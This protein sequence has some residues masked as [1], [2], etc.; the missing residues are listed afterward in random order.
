[1]AVSATTPSRFDQPP[2]EATGSVTVL[3][4]PE[5]AAQH[6]VAAPEALRTLPG[7]DVREA[8]TLGEAA[9]LRIR[10]AEPF[11]T[12]VLLDGVRVNSPLRGDADLGNF[13]LDG[14]TQIE[15]VR[16]GYSA[17]YG[18]DAIGGAVNLRTLP[19]Q[20]PTEVTFFAEGGTFHT[21]REGVGVG[22]KQEWGFYR[23]AV[24]RTDTDG[25]FDH[26]RFGAAT[27]SGQLS[28]DLTPRSSITLTP[29]YQT[30]RKEMAI[31]PLEFLPTFTVVR[32]DNNVIKRQFLSTAVEYRNTPVPWWEMV[33]N[34]STVQ[35]DLDWDNPNTD[36]TVDGSTSVSYSYAEETREREY[37]VN[38]QQNI[39]WQ[40]NQVFT[41]GLEQAWVDVHSIQDIAFTV[42]PPPPGFPPSY[43]P[44]PTA[45]DGRR[46]T[47][48]LYLQQLSRLWDSLMVQAGLRV[49]GDSQFGTT[50]NPKLATTYRLAPTG[51]TLR[52]SGGTAYRAPTIQEL[53]FVLYGN[54][55]LHPERAISWE[56]G[57]R[58]PLLGERLV[59]DAAFFQIE[60][61]NLIERFP[62]PAH[63]VGRARSRGVETEVI[64]QPVDNARVTVNYTWLDTL[65]ENGM[66]LPLSR[67]HRLNMIVT[68]SPLTGLVL[69]VS[70]QLASGQQLPGP[71]EQ[72]D[73]TVE[74]GR[75]SG[76]LLI[77]AT[78]TYELIRP[79]PAVR[80]AELFVKANNLL[81]TDYQNLPG[82]PAPGLA[83]LG[84]IKS[85]F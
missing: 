29:R 47:R 11:Q 36:S 63:N 72:L 37:T 83:F 24:S 54:P 22:G 64:Y 52:A 3:T 48:S 75:D 70:A 50:V 18:S 16:G 73:G 32:D 79:M 51:A 77:D 84:G 10:G 25:Q 15:A 34:V 30:D 17:L 13:L 27:L 35:T 8:G 49:D 31:T 2:D 45:I 81:N 44:P 66:D 20:R 53:D 43:D 9:S 56:A 61:H 12:L 28:V 21:A 68:G 69:R 57:V 58:Q 39:T 42:T 78:A 82:F 41:L 19:P 4:E 60:F 6:P 7:L 5:M 14:V 23:F 67:R 26:D 85:S 71:V 62:A 46:R 55:G 76:Y 40:P 80:Q 59:L 38:L 1:M 74:Y 33:L 65:G